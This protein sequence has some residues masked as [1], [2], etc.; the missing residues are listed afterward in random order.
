MARPRRRGAPTAHLR[1][2]LGQDLAEVRRALAAGVQALEEVDVG[3]E[4]GAFVGGGRVGEARH[5]GV[6]VL[7]GCAAELGFGGFVAEFGGDGV[8]GEGRLGE[9]GGGQLGGWCFRVGWRGLGE[10]VGG[11]GGVPGCQED[12]RDDYG[13]GEEEDAAGW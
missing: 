1:R 2:E 11:C 4:G 9:V 6:Q 8:A 12:Y 3:F 13:E 10:E 5:D 7:P